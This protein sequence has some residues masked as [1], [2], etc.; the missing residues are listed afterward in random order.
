VIFDVKSSLRFVVELLS[1]IILLSFSYK[2][3]FI[4]IDSMFGILN[5]VKIL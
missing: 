5:L 4:I 2:Y 1:T 3:V